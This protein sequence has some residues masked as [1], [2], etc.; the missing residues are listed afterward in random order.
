LL[1]R[2]TRAIHVVTAVITAQ[3]K[4]MITST[5]E[6]GPTAQATAAAVEKPEAP[7]KA[8]RAARSRHVAPSKGKSGK[9]ATSSKKGA[10]GRKQ[11]GEGARLRRSADTRRNVESA[12]PRCTPRFSTLEFLDITP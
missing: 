7:K 2:R 10:T 8:H 9:N 4:N 3:G 5:I 1:L 12:M 6:N 11:A